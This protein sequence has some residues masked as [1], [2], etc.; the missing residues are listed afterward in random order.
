MRLTECFNVFIFSM[1][2]AKSGTIT[3]CI[4]IHPPKN[5]TLN[6]IQLQSIRLC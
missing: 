5:L 6:Q 2:H 3:K 4:G 1:L